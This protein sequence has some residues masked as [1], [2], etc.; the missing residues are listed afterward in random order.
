MMRRTARAGFA[1]KLGR[2]VFRAPGITGRLGRSALDGHG[3]GADL[4]ELLWL[5]PQPAV[6][7]KEKLSGNW[8]YIYSVH[9][10]TSI[11]Q[12]LGSTYSSMMKRQVMHQ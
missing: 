9:T 7:S 3:F 8:K 6:S 12:Y 11:E 4:P 2:H 1:Q 10:G 5:R